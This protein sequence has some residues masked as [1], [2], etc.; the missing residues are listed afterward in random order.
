MSLG[1]L[2]LNSVHETRIKRLINLFKDVASS[3][4][5]RRHAADTAVPPTGC[6]CAGCGCAVTLTV[7]RLL[8]TSHA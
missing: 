2:L 1:E 6:G 3:Q 4:T 7:V 5:H 8:L